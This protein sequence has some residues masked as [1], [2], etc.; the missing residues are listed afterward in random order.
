M[1]KTILMIH[2][3]Q[4]AKWCWDD[5]KSFFDAKGYVCVIPDLRYHDESIKKPH[6]K[7]GNTS[8]NDYLADLED[9]L[10]TLPKDTILMGHSMGGLLALLLNSRGYGSKSVLITPATPYGIVNMSPSSV[11]SF[12]SVVRHWAFWEKPFA[13]SFEDVYY[14]V[15]NLYSKEEARKNYDRL[16]YESG[17]AL[18]EIGF[19]FLDKHKTSYASKE[20]IQTPVLAI[21]GKKDR[22]TPIS[23]IKKMASKYGFK[24]LEYENHAHGILGEKGWE[25][26]AS[27]ILEWLEN[28]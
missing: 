11:K 12:F 3:M 26:V 27:D 16:V 22:T 20:S 17:R 18:F 5:Y 6:P 9:L 8:L 4:G 1:K 7:L 14:G 28:S 23:G 24:Y 25:E 21:A 19:W 15:F 13:Q 10:K 2:G